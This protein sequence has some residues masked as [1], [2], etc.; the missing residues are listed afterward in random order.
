MNARIGSVTLQEKSVI[1]GSTHIITAYPVADGLKGL[2]AGTA[3]KLDNGKVTHLATDADDAMGILYNDV[4]GMD[5]GKSKDAVAQVVVFGSVKK[6]SVS[7]TDSATAC[8]ETLVEKLRKNGIY[9][10]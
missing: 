2:T 6:E 7:Y 8:T 4:I 3:V 10:L 9:A 1:S 5:D